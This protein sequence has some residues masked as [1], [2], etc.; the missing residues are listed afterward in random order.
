MTIGEFE[1]IKNFFA[2]QSIKRDDVILGIGDDAAI[3][4][5]PEKQQ[6]VITTDT[7]VAEVHFLSSANAYDIGFKS[8]AVNLSDLAAMGAVPSWVT[9]SLTLPH[10]KETWIKEFCRGFFDLALQYQTQLIGGDLSQ[11]PL[12]ITVGAFG[13]T[14]P[15]QAITRRGAKPGDLIYVTNTLGEAALALHYPSEKALAKLNRPL[16]Q[17]EI[18]TQLR[19]IA[20]AAI[21]ISDG[22]AADLGHILEESGV[23]ANVNV[24]K[25]PIAKSLTD[26]LSSDDALALALTGGDDYELCFTVPPEKQSLLEKSLPQNQYHYTYIG[27]IQAE[28]GLNLHYQDGK[29]YLGKLYGY[30]HFQK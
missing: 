13:F 9:L 24:D 1:I 20:N 25:I 4:N 8:I 5:V 3:V 27:T 21:D 28:K 29:K 30:Q 23:G 12:S 2:T 16:P 17:I 6:L 14:P 11:G 18:G 19:N 10:V 22:L 26:I 7:L 15:G